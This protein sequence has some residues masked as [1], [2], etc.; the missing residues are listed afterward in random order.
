MAFEW[1]KFWKRTTDTGETYADQTADELI[2]Y[3]KAHPTGDIITQKKRRIAIQQTQ[4]QEDPIVAD[5][6]LDLA[7]F[8]KSEAMMGKDGRGKHVKIYLDGMIVFDDNG[9]VVNG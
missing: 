6:L 1:L 4:C 2:D 7:K 3:F 9:E 5:S 8:P